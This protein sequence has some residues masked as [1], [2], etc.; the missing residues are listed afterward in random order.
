M[1]QLAHGDNYGPQWRAKNRNQNSSIIMMMIRNRN[2]SRDYLFW[3]VAGGVFMSG[4][5]ISSF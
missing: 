3:V 2:L 4:S 5:Q 1:A